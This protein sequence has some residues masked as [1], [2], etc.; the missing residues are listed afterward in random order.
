MVD[1]FAG[2]EVQINGL[3][4]PSHKWVDKESMKQPICVTRW[5]NAT[6]DQCKKM[7]AVFQQSG[8]F[9]ACCHHHLM[10]LGCDM[11]NSG[12]LMKYLLAIVEK[13][14]SVYGCDGAVFYDISCAFS[15]T[16]ANSC[17]APKVSS[18]NLHMVVGAF[19]GHAHNRKCQL[20]W[21]LLYVHGT[22]NMEGEGCE[23]VFSASNNLAQGM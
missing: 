19:H 8:I 13:L 12:E 17:I 6:L 11:I 20:K 2:N 15:T 22:G 21:H 4:N 9:I 3:D 18:L 10:L 14:L 1:N 23:H 16:L 7:F 5:R